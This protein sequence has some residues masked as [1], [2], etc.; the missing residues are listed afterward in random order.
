MR[1]RAF[2]G[3]DFDAA[4]VGSDFVLSQHGGTGP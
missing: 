1:L 2:R 4:F 3:R